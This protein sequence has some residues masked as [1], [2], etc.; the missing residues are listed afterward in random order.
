MADLAARP[1]LKGLIA[2]LPRTFGPAFNDQV[3]QWPML[4]PA[5]RR[6]LDAQIQWLS[7]LQP[8]EFQKLFAPIVELESRMNLPRWGEESRGISVQEAGVLARSPLYPRWRNEVAQIF[9]R[10]D[11]SIPPSPV[12]LRRRL[13]IC[14]LPQGIPI[15]NEPLWPELAGSGS[16]IGLDRPF[17][18]V[19]VSLA[20]ALGTRKLPPDTDPVEST[21]AIECES[22]FVSV[23]GATVL[24]WAALADAR[25][26]FL[27]RLNT[28]QRDLHSV[29]QANQELKRLDIT[30]LVGQRV[31]NDP[32]VREFVRGLF[33]SGNGSLVFPNSFVQWGASE[34]LRR[35]EPLALIAAFG[36]RQK[37]KPFSSTVLFEDQT[38]SNPVKDQ[39]DPAGSLIDA[40]MLAQYV[41]LAMQRVDSYRDRTLSLMAAGDLN[42]IL[43]LGAKLPAERMNGAELA[44][45]CLRWL[46]GG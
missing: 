12:A 39:D 25:R 3:A 35:A 23:E 17:G 29:D 37:L 20:S 15:G 10:M 42:R 45:H 31:G 36:L 5:E 43:V 7:R 14:V 33:L 28:I 26:E 44:A 2:R 40:L 38:R 13:L 18:E 4:F 6:K 21:W 30:R 16:W 8:E 19:F 27:S 11:D 24:S 1:N 34:A 22:R 32:R 46:E 9:A 41:Y